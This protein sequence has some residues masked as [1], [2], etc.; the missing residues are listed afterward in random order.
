MWLLQMYIYILYVY[1]LVV[2][3]VYNTGFLC[4]S[5][6]RVSVCGCCGKYD[7]IIIR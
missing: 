6:D 2:V 5:I 7:D 1:I 3:V 4:V